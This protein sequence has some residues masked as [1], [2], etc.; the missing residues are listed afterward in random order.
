MLILVNP[1][2][3]TFYTHD[4]SYNVWL[5]TDRISVELTNNRFD[6]TDLDWNPDWTLDDYSDVETIYI[7]I[8]TEE[9]SYDYIIH[10]SERYQVDI[11]IVGRI[12]YRPTETDDFVGLRYLGTTGTLN[13]GDSRA[14]TWPAEPIDP[15]DMPGWQIGAQFMVV[16]YFM[17]HPTSDP[18]DY[19]Y[20]IGAAIIEVAAD[21]YNP[22]DPTQT[23]PADTTP[24]DGTD[25]GTTDGTT[26]DDLPESFLEWLIRM[27]RE[28]FGLSDG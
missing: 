20:V 27:L 2:F 26:D 21:D 23:P 9:M 3:G 4:V 19:E 1:A 24:D 22:V 28:L 11:D 8:F 16:W 10:N 5:E 25:D 7:D 17:E 18:S 15:D 14:G 12:F 6:C 13:A